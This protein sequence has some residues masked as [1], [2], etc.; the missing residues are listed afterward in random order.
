[1]TIPPGKHASTSCF[2]RTNHF[3]FAC[4]TPK[5]QRVARPKR[6]VGVGLSTSDSHA[7]RTSSP[8]THRRKL[9][10]IV[11]VEL[12]SSIS[13]FDASHGSLK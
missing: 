4:G 6:S 1:M 13:R 10:S 2:E 9:I 7:L 11:R 8:A 12:F 3:V 5:A